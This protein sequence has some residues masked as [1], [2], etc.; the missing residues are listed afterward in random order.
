MTL[1]IVDKMPTSGRFMMIYEHPQSTGIWSV[2]YEWINGVLHTLFE[3]SEWEPVDY[4]ISETT[5][6]TILGY[7]VKDGR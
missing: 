5:Y 6:Y 1:K 7:I 4:K 3:E 2:T